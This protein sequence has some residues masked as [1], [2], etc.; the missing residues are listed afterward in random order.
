MAEN[1]L[2]T[3]QEVA[4]RLRVTVRTVQRLVQDGRLPV[5]RISR[6]MTRFRSSDVEQLVQAH[7]SVAGKPA[8]AQAAKADKLEV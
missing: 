2:L 1:T 4:A 8:E 7:R 6:K 5:V 3:L